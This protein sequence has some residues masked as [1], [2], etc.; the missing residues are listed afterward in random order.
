[1]TN[2]RY[3][4]AKTL[5][6]CPLAASFAFILI[7]SC[8]NAQASPPGDHDFV[9][10]HVLVSPRPGLPAHAFDRIL[11]ERGGH[12][13]GRV[14]SLDVHIVEVP[15]NA[16][17][18]VAQALS[19]NPH[20]KYAELDTLW[21]P[22][23][24]VP[25]D[26][27]F[28]V[29]WHLPKVN[30]PAAWDVTAG[31]GVVV[32]ILDTGVDSTHPDLAGQLVP[33]WN[34]ASDNSNTGDVY[35]HGTKVAGT[36][37]ALTNNALGVSSLAWNCQLM[38][39][40]ITDDPTY[41]MAST[42]SMAAGLTWAA[43]H[44]ATIANIS[45]DVVGDRTVS[46]AAQYMRNRGGVVLVAA[47]NSGANLSFADDPYVIAV[48]ATDSNDQK[49]SWSNYGASID[50]SAPGVGIWTT[51]RGGGYAAVSGTSF[52]SPVASG[53]AALVRAANP[54]LTPAQV[55]TILEKSAAD[56]VAGSDWHGYFGWG[57]VDAS[58]AVVLALGTIA[59]DTQPP[60][61]GIFN[62]VSGSTVKGLVSVEVSATD[63]AGVAQVELY[64]G[65]TRIGT[66]AVAPYTFT[67]DSNL[68]ADGSIVLTAKAYD[69]A[70][71][72]SSS[73]GVSVT[74][75][76]VPNVVDTTP[77]AVSISNPTNGSVVSGKVN[78]SARAQDNVAV[79]QMK[80][81]IDGKLVSTTTAG[82]LNF[83]W[84]T[85]SASKGSNSLKVVASDAAGNQSQTSVQVSN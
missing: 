61:V 53:V 46:S 38:P 12:S 58:A 9:K 77:P 84:N 42:S 62:P 15:R 6:A 7:A 69:E 16:E 70:Q 54:N 35:G 51:T 20:V 36:V 85:K 49:A 37:G 66:D 24:I 19:R 80:L 26:P 27:N 52:A 33:G 74:V 29:A 65:N 32:A 83:T 64:A 22:D 34:T 43:D 21:A 78:V 60:S 67:W 18:A 30:A 50:I 68:V 55:E 57:R 17:K 5:S 45:Y 73:P 79:T 13:I 23:Q 39:I 59:R 4:S 8:D 76:N 72:A 2:H 44:G 25:N 75:D 31:D 56:P 1:M 47:G 48:S 10:G 81:Y 11:N 82:S 28:P 71:N 14:G 63:N 40:R 41:G 3:R